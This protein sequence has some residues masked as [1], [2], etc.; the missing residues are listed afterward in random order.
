MVTLRPVSFRFMDE[1]SLSRGSVEILE[2]FPR[3][4]GAV[5]NLPLVFHRFHQCRHS[6]W[7]CWPAR[8]LPVSDIVAQNAAFAGYMSAP[9][10]TDSTARIF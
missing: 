3:P 7:L 6:S 9:E 2:G 10:L 5:V 1:R 8:T 4:V